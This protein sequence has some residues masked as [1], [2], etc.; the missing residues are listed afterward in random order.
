MQA[1]QYIASLMKFRDL[2]E[3]DYAEYLEDQRAAKPNVAE[4]F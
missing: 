3:E 1:A 2:Y 4:V